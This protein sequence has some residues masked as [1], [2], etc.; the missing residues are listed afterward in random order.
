MVFFM[1]YFCLVLKLYYFFVA[2]CTNLA[3]FDADKVKSIQKK[4]FKKSVF[5]LEIQNYVT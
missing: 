1:E 3:V 2:F 4:N 5:L